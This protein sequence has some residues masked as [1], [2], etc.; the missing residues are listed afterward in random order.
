MFWGVSK[1]LSEFC[2]NCLCI[3]HT[4]GNLTDGIMHQLFLLQLSILADNIFISLSYIHTLKEHANKKLCCT[5][6]ISDLIKEKN[7][8]NSNLCYVLHAQQ[9]YW[10]LNSGLRRSSAIINFR[11][12]LLDY[13]LGTL[14]H[15]YTVST[16]FARN[17]TILTFF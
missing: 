9:L 6:C 16:Q 3:S 12:L 4:Q 10:I 2:L 13:L 15:N 7:I 1:K 14:T 8:S 17:T 5:Q 11:S